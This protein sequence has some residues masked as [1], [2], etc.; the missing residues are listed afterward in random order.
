MCVTKLLFMLKFRQIL[1][2]NRLLDEIIIHLNEYI[3]KLQPMFCF[4]KGWN[5]KINESCDM[6]IIESLRVQ[7][8]QTIKKHNICEKKMDLSYLAIQIAFHIYKHIV[9]YYK[10]QTIIFEPIY[11]HRNITIYEVS[12]ENMRKLF[13]DVDHF[14][15]HFPILNKNETIDISTEKEDEINILKTKFQLLLSDIV[16]NKINMDTIV[17]KTKETYKNT[18]LHLF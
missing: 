11:L 6:K 14:R 16:E 2:I 10:H 13:I 8:H 1:S 17:T 15:R 18:I 4:P 5:A 9:K 3:S 12:D 7:L